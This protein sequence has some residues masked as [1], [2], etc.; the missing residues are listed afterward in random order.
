MMLPNGSSKQRL[1]TSIQDSHGRNNG[2]ELDPRQLK[3]TKGSHAYS[4]VE[5]SNAKSFSVCN[6]RHGQHA[7]KPQG[8]NALVHLG[9]LTGSINSDDRG[10]RRQSCLSK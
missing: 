9:N 7:P 5:I 1:I 3:G 2:D 4:I 10:T 8:M 6:E